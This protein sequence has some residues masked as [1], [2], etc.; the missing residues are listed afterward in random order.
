MLR[1]SLL[2]S[3]VFLP[4][5]ITFNLNKKKEAIGPSL[6]MILPDLM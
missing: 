3:H 6:F 2:G 5:G 4:M 1:P